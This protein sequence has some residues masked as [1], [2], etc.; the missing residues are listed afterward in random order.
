[1]SYAARTRRPPRTLTRAEVKRLLDVT[2]QLRSTF[3]D[4]V[5][6]S[7]ALGTGL[8][9]HELVALDVDDVVT[10]DGNVRRVLQLRRF[11]GSTRPQADASAQRVHLPGS[12]WYKLEKYVRTER[13]AQLVGQRPRQPLFTS[14]RSQRLSERAVRALFAKAQKVARFDHRYNFHALRHTA[15][16]MVQ[17]SA[18]DVRLTQRFA[19]HAD[20][21]TTLRYEHG[22][23]EQLSAVVKDLPV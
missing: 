12:T 9:C 11:K 15:I 2:G 7:L 8:R 3:R 13:L 21:N 6:L 17:A 1:V 18:R 10:P 16:T 4:H 20:I 19:R 22:G 14:R 23:D 5:L